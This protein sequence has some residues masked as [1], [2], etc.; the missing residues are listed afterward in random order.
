MTDVTDVA[1]EPF[2][3]YAFQQYLSQE[4]LMGCRCVNCDA[5]FVPPRSI[6]SRCH[7]LNMQWQQ[8]QGTGK[9][10]T[11]T[12]IAIG[13]PALAAQGYDRDHPYCCGV[14]ELDEKVR[15]AARI[16]DGDRQG[17]GAVAIGMPVRAAYLHPADRDNGRTV[18][19]FRPI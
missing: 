13:P 15:V 4:K 18:L 3:D 6:C 1:K 11:Y 10:V 2:G 5:L 7:Q 8:M 17:H 12:R 19:A 16:E 9:L 14:V